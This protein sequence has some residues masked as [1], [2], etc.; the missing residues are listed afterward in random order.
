MLQRSQ[1]SWR[2]QLSIP[3]RYVK[4][5]ASGSLHCARDDKCNVRTH[6]SSASFAFTLL[7]SGTTRASALQSMYWI[8]PARS[9]T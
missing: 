1:R 4:D 2:G 5:F 8:T 3:L 9:I 6:F 7:K